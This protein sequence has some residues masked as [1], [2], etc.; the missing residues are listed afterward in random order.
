DE[1]V[2]IDLELDHGIQPL[3]LA[4]EHQVEGGCLLQRAWKAVKNEAGLAVRLLDALGDDA[5]DNVVGNELALLHERLG[6]EADLGSGP[7]RSSQHIARRKLNETALL[8]ELLSLCA[9]AGPRR[10]QQDQFHRRPL[11]DDAP[12]SF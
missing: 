12:R 8:G 6:L 4:I 7:G 11:R 3:A 5:D 9:L 10:P 2:I 1:A